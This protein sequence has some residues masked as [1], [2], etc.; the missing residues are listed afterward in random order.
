[1]LVVDKFTYA[2]NLASLA[3]VQGHSR[4]RFSRSDICNRSAIAAIFS[5][6]D[7]DA[8][9]NLAAESHID[10]SIEALGEFINT[11]VVGN[12]VLLKAAL[13]HWRKMGSRAARFRL[14]HVSSDRF[15]RPD[16]GSILPISLRTRQ[17]AAAHPRGGPPRHPRN[18]TDSQT[19]W[20]PLLAAHDAGGWRSLA[21]QSA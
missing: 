8:V 5:A 6:F 15:W 3:L 17:V 20:Q 7:P 12:Y 4:Y 21:K 11:N 9:M 10:R 16:R 19:W 1:V 18:G 13:V 2:G 14:H